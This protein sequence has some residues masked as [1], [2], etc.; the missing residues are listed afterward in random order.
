MV[1]LG[2]GEK[3]GILVGQH[4]TWKIIGYRPKQL[5]M[6]PLETKTI[7]L[8]QQGQKRTSMMKKGLCLFLFYIYFII[9]ILLYLSIK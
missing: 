4:S 8:S 5:L 6:L 9:F 1:T 2:D 7:K 3:Q